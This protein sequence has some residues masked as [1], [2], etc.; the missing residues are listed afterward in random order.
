M[1]DNDE[2]SNNKNSNSNKRVDN[3]KNKRN[4]T[5]LSV[6]SNN[7]HYIKNFKLGKV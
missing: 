2:T 6:N 4:L 5:L 7:K 1:W 3:K